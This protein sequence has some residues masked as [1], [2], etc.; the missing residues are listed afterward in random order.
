[1]ISVD[2]YLGDALECLKRLPDN[3]VDLISTSPPY[4]GLREYGTEKWIGGK[5]KCKHSG[6]DICLSCGAKKIDK[7]IGIEKTPD[8]YVQKMVEVFREARRVLKDTGVMFLNIGDSYAGSGGAGGDYNKGGRK[9]GQPKYKSAFKPDKKIKHKDIIGI[10]WMVAFALRDDGWYFRSPIIWAKG[11]S[12]QDDLWDKVYRSCLDNGIEEDMAIKIANDVD[13]YVG[14]CMPESV[15]D[16]PSTSHEYIFLMTKS[17]KYFY[18]IDSR[19]ESPVSNIKAKPWKERSYT[20]AGVPGERNKSESNKRGRCNEPCGNNP[21]GRNMRTVWAIGTASFRGAHFA[22]MPT[23][24]SDRFVDLGSSEK[25]CCASCGAPYIRFKTKTGKIDVEKYN[26]KNQ[27]DY[28]KY[29]AQEPSDTKRRILDGKSVIYK[30][31][32]KKTCECND[33]KITPAIVL[34]P[35]CGA[36]TSGVSAVSKGRSFIGIEL[37]RESA[38]IARDRIEKYTDQKIIIHEER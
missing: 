33:N 30:Y 6:D 11:V 26:G 9:E 36:G 24:L 34:D 29:K 7:Q 35:F 27:K 31:D 32:W 4:Y 19:R 25:G 15:T 16:R 14:S 21:V 23:G 18:D 2:L 37:N 28:K 13:P 12:G 5:K 3:Y 38:Q 8:E 10:P 22:V 17:K 1:M 20:G